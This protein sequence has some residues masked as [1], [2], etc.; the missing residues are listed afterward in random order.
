[1]DV[2]VLRWPSEAGRRAE[3]ARSHV[4]R[5]LLLEDG[6]APPAGEDSLGDC[7]EDWV[8]MPAP[9]TELRARIDGLARRGRRHGPASPVLDDDG[10]LRAG[11]TVVPLPPVEARLTRALLERFGAVVSRERLA[12]EAWPGA[13]P[14]RNVLDVHIL[15]LRRRIVPLGLSI[16]TVRCRGYLLAGSS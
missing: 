2:S 9:E 8:R 5:L 14:G 6:S 15:R 3:L 13:T 10:I 11:E 16:R 1:M 4:P 7:L 12:S